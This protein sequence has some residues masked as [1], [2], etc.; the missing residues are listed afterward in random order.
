MSRPKM[1]GVAAPTLE[2]GLLYVTNLY[3]ARIVSM[4][5]PLGE[6]ELDTGEQVRIFTRPEH[7]DGFELDEVR[8]APETPPELIH[9]AMTRYRPGAARG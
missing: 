8:Q 4:L 7:L 9:K 3:H 5:L 1:I 6:F 2:A